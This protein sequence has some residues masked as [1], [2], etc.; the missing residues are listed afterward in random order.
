MTEA[1]KYSF[2]ERIQYHPEGKREILSTAKGAF[3]VRNDRYK[4]NIYPDGDVFLYD[5]ENDPNEM[6]NVIENPKF[7][8]DVL[9]L[10]KAL[11]EWLKTT[12]WKGVPVKFKYL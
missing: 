10:E 12:N 4:L 1:P 5:L 8:Q 7:T 6:K 11:S 9:E 2:C 3:M